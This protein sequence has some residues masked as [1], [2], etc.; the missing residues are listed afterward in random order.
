MWS[1]DDSGRLVLSRGLLRVFGLMLADVAALV[2]SFAGALLLY[3]A[4]GFGHYHFG[5]A[6]YLKMWPMAV[7]YVAVNGFF[8]LYHGNPLYPA[9]PVSPVEELRRLTG[10]SVVVHIGALAALALAYQTTEGYSRAAI[11]L[12]S[13]LLSVVAQ[14]FRDVVR[15]LMR[16]SGL[17]LIPVR[18]CGEERFLP[19][20]KRALS[21]DAHVG[22]KVVSDEASVMIACGTVDAAVVEALMREYPHVILLPDAE[23]YPISESRTVD[24]GDFRGLETKS[25][26]AMRVMR[27]EKLLLDGLLAALAFVFALPLFVIVP[28]LIKLTSRGPVFYRAKRIGRGGRPICVYKFR[29]MYEDADRRL[30]ELL[31]SSPELEAEFSRDFKLRNDPRITPLGKILR[32]TSID[33]L[34]QFFNVLCGDMALIGPRPIVEA[35][36]EHYGRNFERFSSVRP[37]ITGLWQVSGRN[38][39]DYAR[40]VALDMRYICN[41]S[42]WLDVWILRKTFGAVLG[43]KGSY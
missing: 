39:C 13:V 6:V 30:K 10:S 35:E 28:L 14:P 4:V 12:S 26:R 31:E 7:A 29:S 16:R 8:R 19:G 37:G 43:M 34:P 1:A 17:G 40:R 41:W 38:D 5:M 24:M 42:P 15:A 9:S 11:F 27:G 21:G 20:L 32:R 25:C 3:R 23:R 33:E 2:V 22:F 36:R 18:I